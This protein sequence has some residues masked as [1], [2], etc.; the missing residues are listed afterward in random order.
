[1]S[2]SIVQDSYCESSDFS[3]LSY[4]NSCVFT[5]TFS[6]KICIY[7]RH[8]LISERICRSITVL[9]YGDLIVETHLNLPQRPAVLSRSLSAFPCRQKSLNLL[10]LSVRSC[11]HTYHYCPFLLQRVWYFVRLKAQKPAALHARPSLWR[12]RPDHMTGS[13]AV[14]RKQLYSRT[15]ESC[16]SALLSISVAVKTHTH[17]CI[18]LLSYYLVICS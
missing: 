15:H 3:E 18:C 4:S 7:Y 11:C 10:E 5:F 14:G 17:V 8:R 1:M 6:W 16:V 12:R 2:T 13:V 9:K